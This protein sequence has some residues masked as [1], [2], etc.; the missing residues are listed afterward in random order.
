MIAVAMDR[1]RKAQQG[2]P[3]TTRSQRRCCLFR[4][5]RKTRIGRI[6]F[7]CQGAL[8]LK[9]QGPGSDDQRALRTRERNSQCLN[10]API[11]LGGRRVVR[12]V[13]DKGH[14]D[15]PVSGGRSTAQALNIFQ[16]TAMY[17]G[18]CGDNGRGSN[19]RA[20]QGEHPM[21]RLDQFLN[22]CRTDKPCCSRNKYLH[23]SLLRIE[24]LECERS[25]CPRRT[26]KH[27]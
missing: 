7:R 25:E 6:S 2:E 8:A 22:N 13:V 18:S 21:P 9:E 20:S 10:G 26:K 3:H 16:R 23:V 11:L 19:L 17:I 12:E 27:P 5:A 1:W 24:Y 14:V 4:L 15:D